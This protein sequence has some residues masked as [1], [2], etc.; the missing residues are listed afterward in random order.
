[1]LHALFL[2]IDQFVHVNWTTRV[3][4][5]LS[6]ENVSFFNN[7]CMTWKLTTH[8][9]A[10]GCNNDFECSDSQVCITRNCV[11]PCLFDNPCGQNA[12]CNPKSH[13]AICSCIQSHKGNPYVRCDPYECLQDPDCPTDLK[14]LSEK[15][16]DPCQCAQNAECA[17]RNHRGI[18]TCIPDFTGDP[19]GIACSP[20]SKY[21]SLRE[22]EYL[23]YFLLFFMPY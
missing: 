4:L 14:C 22:K 15:C 16:V 8:F 20:I 10:A 21:I 13:R 11:D 1:M 23:L 2:S 18:C 5:I 12:K 6:A 7:N 19:Y 3:T 17:A 9:I